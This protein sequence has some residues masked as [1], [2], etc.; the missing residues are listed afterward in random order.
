MTT[1]FSCLILLF[2][3]LF[4]VCYAKSV[5]VSYTL[6]GQHKSLSVNQVAPNSY[7]TSFNS[8][9]QLRL[10]TLDWPPYIDRN[11]CDKGWVF[12]FSIALFHELG[13]DVTIDFLPWARAVRMA[14]L[15]KADILFPEYFIETTAPSDIIDNSFR[16]D[17]LALSNAFA[18]GPIGLISRAEF[19]AGYDG[20][21]VSIR[22][23]KIG[24]VRGYQNTPEFDRQLDLGFFNAM[25]ARDDL[26]NIRLLLAGRV[27]YIVADRYVIDYLVEKT[28]PEDQGKI[29]FLTP[30]F[31]N[32]ELFYAIS[33]R[34]DNWQTLLADLNKVLSN[35]QKSDALDQFKQQ[36]KR[37]VPS[38]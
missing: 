8:G 35:F 38:S 18:S 5:K 15:G 29:E 13:I 32:N 6:N 9:K 1:R 11:L 26:H 30:A 12:Q 4:P 19:K 3:L 36:A 7:Q 34:A 25:E 14:E 20:S 2:S 27:D 22:G 33:K 37:C 21:M 17:N 28:Y 16:L 24:V 31:Q 10:V 23:A